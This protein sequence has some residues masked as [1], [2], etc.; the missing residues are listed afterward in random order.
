MAKSPVKVDSL[1]EQITSLL[2]SV[3]VEREETDSLERPEP[4]LEEEVPAR[5]E[6]PVQEEISVRPEPPVEEEVRVRPR[7]SPPRPIEPPR[8]IERTKP[9]PAPPR[10]RKRAKA[11]PARRKSPRGAKEAPARRK[12]PQVAKEAAPRAKSPPVPQ[13]VKAQRPPPAKARAVAPARR[14][15]RPREPFLADPA[16]RELAFFVIAGLVFGALIG[17]L[18]ALAG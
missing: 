3:V 15:G 6:P 1:D 18:V 14:R 8:Q 5:P 17:L 16:K 4:P 11:A 7:R 10:A 2:E 12:A 9:S 13:V